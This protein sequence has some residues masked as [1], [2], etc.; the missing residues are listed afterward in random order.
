MPQDSPLRVLP[1]KAEQRCHK[2]QRGQDDDNLQRV[3][4]D[5]NVGAKG[6]GALGDDEALRPGLARLE[7][8]RGRV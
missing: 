5:T 7:A 6:H 8:K 3:H 4:Q 2:K 1:G